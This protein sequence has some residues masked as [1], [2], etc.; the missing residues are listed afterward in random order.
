L[1][2]IQE[3]VNAGLFEHLFGELGFH[4]GSILVYFFKK[5]PLKRKKK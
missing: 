1:R 2:V 5:V 4:H 3:E